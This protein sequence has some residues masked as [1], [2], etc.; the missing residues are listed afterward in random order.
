IG[1]ELRLVLARGFE[2]PAFFLD[3][4]EQPR[5]LNRDHRLIGESAKKFHLS[6]GKVT[7]L[8]LSDDDRS[9][10][11]AVLEHRNRDDAAEVRCRPAE[12]VVGVGM[13]IWNLLDG[14]I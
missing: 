2:L 4:A 10:R 7:A 11:P 13:D 6:L 12:F 8:R 14:A 9:D 1:E 5:V 3:L